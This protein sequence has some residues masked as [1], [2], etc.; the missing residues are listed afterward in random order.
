MVQ[1]AELKHTED[2]LHGRG[3][4]WNA[5]YCI[6]LKSKIEKKIMVFFMKVIQCLFNMHDFQQAGDKYIWQVIY[7]V[8]L[9]EMPYKWHHIYI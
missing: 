2:G 7:R 9:S 8:T 1:S 4:E 6:I 3:V 5:G